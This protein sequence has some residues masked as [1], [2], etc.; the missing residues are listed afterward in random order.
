MVG[1]IVVFTSTASVHVLQE[2]C[3]LAVLYAGYGGYYPWYEK[4][5][6]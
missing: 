4:W 3:T 6:D 5:Y 2:V 1:G